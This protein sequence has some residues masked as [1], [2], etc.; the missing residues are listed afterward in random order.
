MSKRE[1]ATVKESNVAVISERP[2]WM[3]DNGRGNEG[4]TSADI[5]IPRLEIVQLLSPQMKKTSADYNPDAEPGDIFNSVTKELL[6]K[7]VIIVPVT[8]QRQY[9][10]WKKRKLPNGQS[11]EGGYGGSFATEREAVDALKIALEK[12]PG[13]TSEMYEVVETGQ[14]LC[15]LV[16]GERP[17]EIMLS[18]AKSKMKIN[19]NF[20]T[21]IQMTGGDR[22][23]SVYQLSTFDDSNKAGDEY[24]NWKIARLGY[25]PKDIY[26]HAEKLYE[27]VVRGQVR[28]ADH[29]DS[30]DE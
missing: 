24:K 8:Y 5:T 27:S 1:V 9:L 26:T 29:S 22:F 16:G 10:L 20:N 3:K 19:K 6:G 28:T 4:V 30:N 11:T 25:A 18:L 21:L 2:E 7:S 12:N 13:H 23:S 17:T 15:L 14:H